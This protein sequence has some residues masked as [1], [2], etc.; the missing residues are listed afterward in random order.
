M[1][2]AILGASPKPDRYSNKAQQML[3]EYGHETIGVRPGMDE[4]DGMPCVPAIG[5]ISGDIDTVTVYVSPV[6]SA[7]MLDQLLEL[8][9][10]RVIFN[11]DAENPDLEQP[12]A[13]A[14]IEVVHAC[15]MV[16]LRT[17]QY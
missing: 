4:I 11:P 15:T 16:L 14:G 5:D 2:T 10:R 13:D 17:N 1:R 7:G 8:K 3:K 6:I 12:L 9:P